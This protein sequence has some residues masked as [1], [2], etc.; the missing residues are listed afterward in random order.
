[1]RSEIT[2]SGYLPSVAEAQI[3]W[4]AGPGPSRSE[5]EAGFALTR[6]L[7]DRVSPSADGFT[8]ALYE[9]FRP[10]IP[11]GRTGHL[12]ILPA[13]DVPGARMDAWPAVIDSWEIADEA[14]GARLYL[15]HL[16]VTG[17]PRTRALVPR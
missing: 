2:A 8:L 10:H 15:A 16:S 7:A 11:D 17:R 4:C 13:G 5:F 14:D 6:D 1:M 3:I 12:C 9:D